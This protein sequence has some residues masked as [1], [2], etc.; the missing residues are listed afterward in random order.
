MNVSRG[1]ALP[2]SICHST[3]FYGQVPGHVSKYWV[4]T[5]G[6]RGVLTHQLE[7]GM[8]SECVVRRPGS[9]LLSQAWWA[10]EE[11][12]KRFECYVLVHKKRQESKPLYASLM[13][14]SIPGTHVAASATV[15]RAID[16]F[17]Q[18]VCTWDWCSC[19][20]TIWKHILIFMHYF[21]YYLCS[22]FV[23]ATCVLWYLLN[24]ERNYNSVVPIAHESDSMRADGPEPKQKYN[25]HEQWFCI[26][27]R[28]EKWGLV[29]ILAASP[30]CSAE[31]KSLLYIKHDYYMK[32]A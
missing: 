8:R 10:T 21:Y 18:T 2:V 3:P 9:V 28:M 15:A 19:D 22:N 32:E 11:K 31:T 20:G 5:D 26:C 29:P 30:T 16:L 27:D 23:R 14:T 17:I 6:S 25:L 1:R 13:A 7:D 4:K 12:P 24:C